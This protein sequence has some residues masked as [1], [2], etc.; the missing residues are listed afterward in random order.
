M[1]A[2]LPKKFE[3]YQDPQPLFFGHYQRSGSPHILASNAICLDWNYVKGN[4]QV[5][6][7]WAR[8]EPIHEQ[9]LVAI[10]HP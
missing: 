7:R 10:Y 5:A 6:Y 4:A 2:P 8:G 9:N 3:M 1:H